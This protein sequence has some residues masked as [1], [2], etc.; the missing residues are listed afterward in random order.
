M[1]TV[2]ATR[3]IELVAVITTAPP[4]A[5]AF[6]KISDPAPVAFILIELP[7]LRVIASAALIAISAPEAVAF[8]LRET[9]ELILVEADVILTEEPK[10]ESGTAILIVLFAA[11]FIKPSDDPTI[12]L[13]TPVFKVRGAPVLVPTLNAVTEPPTPFGVNPS[14]VACRFTAKFPFATWTRPPT[15]FA[16]DTL[17]MAPCALILIPPA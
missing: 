16:L 8:R 11:I 13:L 5:V 4:T 10:L 2:G 17:R 3:L 15:L 12:L 14:P 1:L 9:V 6:R 7:P